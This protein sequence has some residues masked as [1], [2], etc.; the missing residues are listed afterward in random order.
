M[1]DERKKSKRG[2]ARTPANQLEGITASPGIC[3]GEAFVLEKTSIHLPR[4]W[5]NNKETHNEIARFNQAIQKAR[6]EVDLIKEKLCKFEGKEQLHILEAY[7]LILQDEMLTQNTI[8]SIKSEHINAEW[9]LYKNLEKIKDVFR[10]VDESH[11]RERTSDFNYIGERILSHLVGKSEDLFKN[12][13]AQSIIVAHDLSP[14]EASQLM[15]FKIRGIVT[16]IGGKT[17]HTAIISRALEIPAVVGCAGVTEKVKSGDRLII[18]GFNGAVLLKPT[19]KQE[20]EYELHRQHENALQ[21]ILLKDIHLPAT[22]PDGHR[23]RLAANM[24]LTEEIHSIKEH[25]AEGIGLYRTEFLFL[26]RKQPPTEEEHFENY[27]KVLK[28][29]YPNYTTIRTLDLGG[30]K[31]GTS[32]P[33]EPEIN[34]ALGLRAIRLCFKEKQLFRTQVRAM[35]RASVYGKLK[36]LL[37]M[38]SDIEELRKAK[39]IF[40]DVKEDL[41]KEKIDFDPRVKLGIMIE[42]PSAV[43]VADELAREVDFFSIGT[44]DLIQY[45][46]AIDRANENVAYL[47]RPLHPAVLRMLEMAVDAAHREQIEVSVCGEMASEP[48]YILILMGFGLDELSMNALSIPKAKKIIRSVDYTAARAL[49]EKTLLLKTASEMNSFVRKELSQLL[50]DQFKEYS[51]QP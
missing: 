16:E 22:T 48:M 9:A 8:Q 13:P 15:K 38:I 27:K 4:Y 32:H 5:V 29:I 26:N 43:M 14:A 11:F 44:N 2:P 49:M 21:K 40:D 10:N 51:L 50:G 33:Y 20:K 25:G 42:V 12:I 24:E 23:I 19:A 31:V 28:S 36:I 18:D 37:P 30:D 3:V 46:L 6:Q 7:G 1:K 17:S 45:T 39:S 34:P 41:V 47:Y 35:L